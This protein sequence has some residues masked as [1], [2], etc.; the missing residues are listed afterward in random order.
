M[1]DRT[2]TIRIGANVS[3]YV[4][5]IKTMAQA[6]ADAA[7]KAQSWTQE[8]KEGLDDVSAGLFK[9]GV[10]LTGF[11]AIA[12]SKFADFDQAMSGVGAATMETADNMGLLR[13]AALQAGADTQYS[14]TEAAEGIT[15]LAKAGVKTT[16][17]LKGGLTGA[18]NLAAS[19]QMDVGEA[20]E[21]TATA[22]NQYGLEGKDASHVADLL[23]ASAGKAMG[24]V[25]DMAGALKYVGPVAHQMGI[26]IE[27]TA[28][29]I[30]YLAQ[31]GV[32]G[33][34]AG[35]SLRGMLSSL[36]SPSKV[37]TAEMEK[38][39]ISV[40]D[41]NGQFI[42]FNGVAEQLRTK[43]TDLTAAERDQ[44][45]GRIFGNEQ[46][47]TARLLYA[48]GA[49]A[50]DTWTDA[51]NDS[52]YA[53]EQAQ[54]K[55]DN[56]KGDIER[57]GGS[58]DTALIQS[59]SGANDALRN[60]AQGA[61]VA[62]NK[63]GELPSPLLNA[64]T[65][66]A[67]AG[68]LTVL[69]IS[70][71]LK[72]ATSVTAAKAT[73]AGLNISMKTAGISAGILGGALLIGTA[74]F[75]L[76]A[77]A[78]ADAQARTDAFAG[79]L[80]D[81]GNRTDATLRTIN[82]NLSKSNHTWHSWLTD[83][84]DRSA[85]DLAADLGIAIEDV[86]GAIL[87]QADAQ[88]R[89]NAVT[90]KAMNQGVDRR[91]AAIEL[92]SAIDKQS[93]ALTEAE[94]QTARNALA[95]KAA[96]VAVDEHKSAIEKYAV[97]QSDG[98]A[99]TEDYSDALK[100]LI[101]AQR[102]AAGVV[103][104]ERDAQRQLEASYQGVTDALK[105]QVDDL[106]QQYEAQGIGTEAARKRA[107]AEVAVSDKLDITTEAGRRNQAA[108]DDVAKSGWDLID[109]M[110]ENGATQADLQATMQTTRDRFIGV[111][112]QMGL[113]ADQANALA[114]ELNLIPANV[115]VAVAV[116]TVNATQTLA[117]WR[118]AVS[119]QAITIQARVNADPSFSPAHSASYI[120]KADGG[121]IAG[122][123]SGT[124]DSIPAYLSNGEYVIKA[125]A[126]AR[127]GRAHFDS[128]NAMRYATGGMV[129][130]RPA[131]APAA[132]ANAGWAPTGPA[133]VHFH[134]ATINARDE[135]AAAER[136]LTK[137]RDAIAVHGLNSWGVPQ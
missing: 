21:I 15:A 134:V 95:D 12:V 125:S 90:E 116:D 88:E 5:G 135:N 94:K 81:F 31:Q 84:D 16:D 30:A 66:L 83:L 59:G 14:A 4:A 93:T 56:L 60:L 25:T 109:S 113:S 42:G 7:S 115:N 132:T 107:E 102:E 38:L 32:V 114:D 123:G 13:E 52:G 18:L 34:E 68:G 27:E 29:T 37:A 9:A 80:D 106:A 24:D 103:L 46:I 120:A 89:V 136:L 26:S 133:Q 11:A 97:A 112:G 55:T 121:Y 3:G 44:S 78:Q 23:A 61:E 100:E 22:L 105:Q 41:T 128:L 58:I 130:L 75:S 85:V 28:G 53:A 72:L 73:L 2:L 1:A 92:N 87:G 127:Y 91:N 98:T 82:E 101:D 45:F 96:G 65:L 35:T 54:I 50:V 119:K 71:M 126:V 124:S 49:D 57:L 104:S 47:T 137:A 63:I 48:G 131:S 74:A 122:R 20:A 86:Q 64:T 129:A 33:S 17:I 43:M 69:G 118:A 77:S 40:Y 117:D 70:G 110:R 8:H 62:V 111:A 36:T 108:L 6:T 99:V 19:A 76:W 79:T 10:G 51:V 67:G 39:R